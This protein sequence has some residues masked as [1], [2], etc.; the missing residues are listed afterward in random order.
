MNK[1]QARLGFNHLTAAA[2]TWL[3]LLC[4]FFISSTLAEEKANLETS[5]DRALLRVIHSEDLKKTMR[6][7]N[8]LAYE[9]EYT[10]LELQS[11]RA[12]QVNRL[13]DFAEELTDKADRLPEISDSQLSESD[14]ITFRAMA[15]Q[16]Y[17]DTLELKKSAA[18]NNYSNM[19]KRY[20]ELN[21]TCDSCHRLFRELR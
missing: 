14:R 16:L 20:L 19:S 15:Q 1:L 11:L 7:L 3:F 17:T 8:L 6:S 2:A 12:A 18:E 13:L 21:K 4:Y 10:E 9:N 5:G